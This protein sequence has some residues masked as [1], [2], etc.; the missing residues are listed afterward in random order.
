MKTRRAPGL[1]RVFQPDSSGPRQALSKRVT[2]DGG[3]AGPAW[4]AVKREMQLEAVG[5]LRVAQ[6]DDF[7]ARC[8]LLGLKLENGQQRLGSQF[9]LALDAYR[10]HRMTYLRKQLNDGRP[11]RESIE[12]FFRDILKHAADTER[13]YGCMNCNQAVEL[14]PEDVEVRKLVAADFQPVEDLF[15]DAIQRGQRDGS[16]RN[17]ESARALARFLTV[18]LQGLQVM[19]RARGDARR[20][21]DNVRVMTGPSPLSPLDIP[22][23]DGYAPLCIPEVQSVIVMPD[24]ESSILQGTLDLM[25]LK[26]LEHLGPLHGYGIALRIEQVGERALIVNQGTVY[27]CLVRLVQKKWI[28]A[29]W[30]VSD[31]NRKAKFYSLTKAGRKQLQAETENWE[32]VA[33][34]MGRVLHP[35]T[36]S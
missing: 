35:Q 17:P 10:Q 6:L 1:A 32:R 12:G 19:A 22:Q 13:P 27:L 20:I 24:S 21:T 16:I 28:R 23:D 9:L 36:G 25:V 30:G 2:T 29:E 7:G 4:L 15:C 11:A 34:V 33:G 31:N 5:E 18:N 14:G 26:T 3:V 8:Q